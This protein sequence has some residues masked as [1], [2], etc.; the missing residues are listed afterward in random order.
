MPVVIRRI[1]DARFRN[2]TRSLAI[3][4][5][6][7]HRSKLCEKWLAANAGVSLNTSDQWIADVG[8]TVRLDAT[9][10]PHPSP[11]NV[12]ESWIASNSNSISSEY[13]A[14]RLRQGLSKRDTTPG[15]QAVATSGK[16]TSLCCQLVGTVF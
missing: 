5:P 15:N 14:I 8:F 6:G 2:Y 11:R 3:R 13:G 9:R 4:G 12:M 10:W 1:V 16:D 7:E